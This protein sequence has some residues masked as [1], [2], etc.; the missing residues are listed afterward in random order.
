MRG[1]RVA[2]RELSP[3]EFL[4]VLSVGYWDTVNAGERLIERGRP[5]STISLI[6]R[7]KV[8][9]SRDQ[10]VIGDLGF[11]EIVGSALTNQE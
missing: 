2:F 7:G 1:R 3:R 10:G 6:V 4:Q 9:V 11:G 8:R 5:V